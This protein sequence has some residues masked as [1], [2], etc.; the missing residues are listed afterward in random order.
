MDPDVN[1]QYSLAGFTDHYH[2]NNLSEGS[3]P[4]ICDTSIFCTANHEMLGTD[5][6]TKPVILSTWDVLS[7]TANHVV[8][9]YG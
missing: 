9:R 5:H 7:K 3:N 1:S 8:E 4:Y 6:V 2:D